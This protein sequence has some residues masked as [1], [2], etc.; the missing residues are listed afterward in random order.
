MRRKDFAAIYFR[1]TP[2]VLHPGQYAGTER[3]ARRDCVPAKIQTILPPE[4]QKTVLRWTVSEERTCLIWRAIRPDSIWNRKGI[5][6]HDHGLG[7]RP[8]HREKSAP[9]SNPAVGRQLSLKR[10]SSSHAA[11]TEPN[12]QSRRN[13]GR[14]LTKGRREVSA[15]SRKLKWVR[16]QHG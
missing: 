9:C 3:N 4:F 12:H 7:G 8:M 2:D 14:G 10:A 15:R 11:A 1:H 13:S 5:P 6:D 16:D